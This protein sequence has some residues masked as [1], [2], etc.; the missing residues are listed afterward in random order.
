M[1]TE[2]AHAGDDPRRLLSNTRELIQRVRREQRATWFPLLV[3]AALTFLS[4]PVRRFSGH[5]MTCGSTP[6]GHECVSYSN[7]DLMYWPVALVLAYVAIVT[8]SIRRTR[9]RGIDTRTRPYAVA[10]TVIAVALAGL[11]FWEFHHPLG[12]GQR[13]LGQVG[14]Q[15]RL[16]SPGMAIGLALLLLARAERNRFLLLVTL[17]YLAVVLVPITFGP[18]HFNPPWYATPVVSQGTVLLLAGIGFAL[19]QRPL[20]ASTP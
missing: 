6:A 18:S 9:A 1:T 12:A 7:A 10:G 20:R 11:A 13:L 2:S 3:F 17:V 14:L 15:Y 5:H 4:I 16:A 19:V 8:F